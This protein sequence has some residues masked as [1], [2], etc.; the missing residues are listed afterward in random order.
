MY[1]YIYIYIYL[2]IYICVYIYLQVW[3]Q[4]KL[5]ILYIT[6]KKSLSESIMTYIYLSLITIFLIGFDIICIIEINLSHFISKIKYI[7]IKKFN[8]L[9]HLL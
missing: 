8:F 1:I 5:S 6:I 9:S 2:H 7:N 4:E 3:N